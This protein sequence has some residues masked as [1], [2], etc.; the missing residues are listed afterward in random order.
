MLLDALGDPREMLLAFSVDEARHGA[1]Q[2]AEQLTATPLPDRPKLIAQRALIIAELGR[3]IVRPRFRTN[4][5]R[6]VIR[7][8]EARDPRR[9]IHALS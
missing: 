9:I 3:S 7:T 4:W 2:F 8:R 5:L 6:R 1:W